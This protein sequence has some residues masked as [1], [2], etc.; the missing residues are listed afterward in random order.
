[1]LS[2]YLP[3]YGESFPISNPIQELLAFSK[4]IALR[5]DLS[6]QLNRTHSVL[7]L[8]IS[9]ETLLSLSAF[10]ARWR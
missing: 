6:L 8:D 2:C 1:M 9:K 3:F 5:Q 7:V 10:H 4:E